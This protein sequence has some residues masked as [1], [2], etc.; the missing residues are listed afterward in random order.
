MLHRTATMYSSLHLT[1]RHLNPLVYGAILWLTALCVQAA[2]QL[3]TPKLPPGF[4]GQAYSG[5]LLIGS[6][7]PLS[8]AGV[9]GLPAGMTA[10]HNGS[11]SVAIS[12]TPTAAGSFTLSVT[13]I[14]NAAGALNTSVTLTINQVASNVTAVAA[15]GEHSCAV[16][17][18]GV[19]CWGYNGNGQLG[20]NSTAQSNVPVQAIIAGS[21]VTA[22]S[23]GGFHSCA[24]VS[25]GSVCW[26]YNGNA[27][28]ADTY[29]N[30][31]LQPVTTLIFRVFK[32]PLVPIIF[33]FLD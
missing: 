32:T 1:P 17:N 24:A 13:A 12:G 20:N 16:V 23:A 29:S 31:T 7:L 3:V 9:T 18:G 26:G 4:Q 21:S 15:G 33:F 8:S 5:S 22:V 25:G 19:Q 10:T 28:L 30:P 2:P 14:D 6:A 27:Q 11:G